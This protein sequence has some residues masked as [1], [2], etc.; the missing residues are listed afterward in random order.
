MNMEIIRVYSKDDLKQK[1][2]VKLIKNEPWFCIQDIGRILKLTNVHRTIRN[3]PKKGITRSS[4]LTGG[5]IQEVLYCDEPNLYRLIFKSRVTGA[6]AFQDWVF[7]DV[8]PEI[9]KTKKIREKS[10]STRKL[11]TDAWQ[12]QGVKTPKEYAYLTLEEYK[13]LGYGKIRKDNMTEEQ[14]RELLALEAIELVKLSYKENAGYSGCKE[15]IKESAKTVKE[16]R[17]KA[18]EEIE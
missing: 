17:E 2:R 11:I 12:G 7:E 9:R 1:I 10:K 4:T 18:K 15:T 16:I 6:K 14:I 5:G 3:L 8:L 13:M